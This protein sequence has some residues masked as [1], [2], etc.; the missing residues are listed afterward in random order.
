MQDIVFYVVA[1]ETDGMLRDY[2]NVHTPEESPVF[3][4]GVSVCLRMRLFASLDDTTPFPIATF[5]GISS[6]QWSMGADFD[7]RGCKLV[8]DAD[9]IFVHTV[10]D[11]IKGETAD[12]TEFVIPI[13]NMN[14]EEIAAWLGNEKKKSGLTGELIGYDDEG[15]AVFGLQIDGFT[16]RNR[17]SGLNDPTALDQEIVTRPVA[18]QMIQTAVSASA[19][20]KQDKLTS[21]NAG[22]GISISSAGVISVSS[23][24]QSSVSGLSE[25]LAS[26][27]DNITAG[28]RMTLVN[29]STVDQSR[30]FAIEPTITA[31]ANQTKTVVLSAGK[32]YEIHATA[33]NA[34]VLLNW[35]TP[36]GGSR[37]FGLEGHIEIFVAGTGNVQAGE[38]VVLANA[39]EPDAVNN[40]TVRFHDGLA[41]ISVED[42]VAGYIVTTAGGT[43]SGSLYYGLAT[44]TNEYISVDASLNGQTLNLAGVTTRAGEKHVVGNGYAETIVS[45]GISCTS[46]T[47]FSNL[48]MQDVVVNGGTLTLG[49]ANILSG[50]T[51]AVNSGA[52]AIEKVAG[53]GGTIDLGGKN[54]Y[55][56]GSF[57]GVALQNGTLASGRLTATG[58]ATV[59]LA[60]TSGTSISFANSNR[61][62]TISGTSAVVFASNGATLD[63]TGNTNATPINPGKGIVFAADGA[64]V[65]Y[66][67]DSTGAALGSSGTAT[68]AGGTFSQLANGGTI[69]TDVLGGSGSYDG[70][71]LKSIT[72]NTTINSYTGGN[73]VFRNCAFYNRISI[74]STNAAIQ[75][76]LTIGGTITAKNFAGLAISLGSSSASRVVVTIEPNTTIDATSIATSY[77]NIIW[78]VAT[79][80]VGSGVTVVNNGTSVAVTAGT[81]SNVSLKKDGSIVA[82]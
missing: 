4:L 24:P 66:D 68:I 31:S 32:A 37:T 9:G 6:W 43:A 23:L 41:I 70:I 26:K 46:K 60:M 27:Q 8:A 51:V 13:S 5:S 69:I 40:C 74:S 45:G 42:H 21:T 2:V 47:T 67:H 75:I 71:T 30:Y 3:T 15:H 44:A 76:S 18:E 57:G 73:K 52:L 77:P 39:L 1:K 20:T 53:D 79:L 11:T 22:T 14:T 7:R 10:T 64:S 28:Y 54:V 16:L 80:I 82:I 55:G 34:M 50:S 48:S 38:N 81:Y 59:A 78:T 25:T 72:S 33:T 29:G 61:V 63:M 36:V 49:D 56:N 12:Y 17:V 19:A 58:G 35:E 62:D 65:I